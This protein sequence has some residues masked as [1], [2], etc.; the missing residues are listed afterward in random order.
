MMQ[1]PPPGW[2]PAK[3]QGGGTP[4]FTGA[5]VITEL[6]NNHAQP[7]F[8]SMHDA[9]AGNQNWDHT[10]VLPYR[11]TFRNWVVVVI[12]HVHVKRQTDG[13]Y[14]QFPGN[15]YIPGYANWGCPTPQFVLTDAPQFNP[16]VHTYNRAVRNAHWAS[17][18]NADVALFSGRTR[19]PRPT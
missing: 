12:A 17:D 13:S 15:A 11:V 5:D 2:D 19:Y 3:C 1:Q 14:H 7:L 16:A 6:G 8:I 4:T 18:T 9:D 10:F